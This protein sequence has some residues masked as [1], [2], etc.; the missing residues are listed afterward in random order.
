MSQ[1]RPLASAGVAALGALVAGVYLLGL[2][3]DVLEI[4]AAQYA[5]MS[6]EM[7]QTGGWLEI[8]DRGQ[9]YLNKPP[10]LFW[11]SQLSFRL[12]GVSNVAYRLPSLLVFLLGIFSTYK[13]AALYGGR[14]AGSLAA[15]V[16]ATCQGGFLMIEDVRTDTLLTG[17]VAFT[18]WQAAEFLEGRRL[19]SAALAGAGLGLGMLAKGQ[20]A[21]MVPVLAIASDAALKRDPRRLL[22]PGWLLTA[23]IGLALLVPMAVGLY[24]QHGPGGLEF[25]FWTQGFGRVFSENPWGDEHGVLFFVPQMLWIFLPWTLVLVLALASRARELRADGWRVANGAEAVA[26]GGFVLAFVGLSLSK[27][28]LPHYVYVTLPSAAVVAGAWL[29]GLER[30]TRPWRWLR[31]AQP[32]VLLLIWA[33]AL[34]LLL[35][36]FPGAPPWLWAALGLIAAWTGL[37]LGP[38]RL[39]ARSTA[40]PLIVASVLTIVAANLALNGHVFPRLLGYQASARAGRLVAERAG[41]EAPLRT[42]R[43]GGYALDFYARRIALPAETVEALGA[44]VAT[45]AGVAA[46]EPAFEPAS[47]AAP[48][49]WVFTDAPGLAEIADA[50]L[51]PEVI[52]TY[53]H[54]RVSRLTPR[55]LDPSARDRATKARVLLRIAAPR[56]PPGRSR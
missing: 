7:A 55:F 45:P 2:R 51:A 23:G 36:L 41:A 49:L 21:L 42:Y 50:G 15:V 44:A 27:S 12:F 26:L 47:E 6:R 38:T 22:R 39:A 31:V 4:D 16:L 9:P 35:W 24:R 37:S 8:T 29:A 3:L 33:F 52:A 1:P 25:H 28:K 56:D 18:L 32:A 34:T 53:P 5:A 11:A 54:F 10:L 48:V 14:R 46:T 19:S 20:I 17:L 13:L 40:R 43:V 30:E